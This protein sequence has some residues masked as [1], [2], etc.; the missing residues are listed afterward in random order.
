VSTKL[1]VDTYLGVIVLA[2]SDTFMRGHVRVYLPR[3]ML[4]QRAAEG[5]RGKASRK[6]F[7]ATGRSAGATACNSS[8]ALAR[9]VLPVT[10]QATRSGGGPSLSSREEHPLQFLDK[11]HETLYLAGPQVQSDR[12]LLMLVNQQRLDGFEIERI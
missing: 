11:Q 9:A 10:T 12:V 6:G 3:K 5:L 7:A 8:I 1:Y 2:G 4:R